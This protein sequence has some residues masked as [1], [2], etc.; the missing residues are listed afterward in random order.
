MNIRKYGLPFGL[1]SGLIIILPWFFS[2]WFGNADGMMTN[3][4]A[5]LIGYGIMVLALSAVFVGVRRYREREGGGYLTFGKGFGLGLG[6]VLVAS[7]IYV[8]GWMLF[9]E[10]YA[11]EFAEN[12]YQGQI[13]EMRADPDLTEAEKDAKEAEWNEGM[14]MYKNPFFRAAITFTEVFP[15]GL[16]VALISALVWMRRPPK[17]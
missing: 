1:V 14:E 6:M 7:V 3:P 15:V 13:A 12:Y 8:I 9:F 11:P 10:I 5:M 4:N 2:A 16:V 17:E